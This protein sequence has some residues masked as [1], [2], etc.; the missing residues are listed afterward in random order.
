MSEERCLII[1]RSNRLECLLEILVE[2][3]RHTPLPPLEPETVVV[4]NRGMATWLSRNLALR[5]N[6]WANPDFPHPR[7]FIDSLLGSALGSEARRLD[8]FSREGLSLALLEILPTLL[9]QEEFAPIARYLTSRGPGLH[10]EGEIDLKRLQLAEKI[11][12]LF[13]QYLVYRTDMVLEWERGDSGPLSPAGVERE[14]RWQPVL[15]RKLAARYGSPAQLFEQA[16]I[17]L[18]AGRLEASS[19]L[20]TRVFLFGVTTLPPVYLAMVNAAARILPIHLLLFSPSREYWADLLPPGEIPRRLL[21]RKERGS[22]GNQIQVASPEQLHLESG[23]PLLA[24]WGKIGREFQELIEQQT[25]YVQPEGE[26]ECFVAPAVEG[27]LH[28]KGQQQ[29][30]SLLARLQSDILELHPPGGAGG[31]LRE[32]P[33]NS[34]VIHCCHSPLREVEVLQ[35]QLL[36]MF[37]AEGL[38]PGEAVVMVPDIETYAP[39]IEAVF[40]RP[41]HDRRFIPFRIADRRLSREAP[42]LDALLELFELSQSRLTLSGVL[43]F[44]SREPVMSALELDS[45]RLRRIEQWLNQ[46]AVRWGIDEEDRRRYEQPADRQNTWLFGLDRLILGY[47]LPGEGS[48]LFADILPLDD[49]EGQDAQLAGVLLRTAKAVFYLAKE[50]HSARS[51]EGWS[52]LVRWSLTTFFAPEERCGP[53]EEW[54]RQSLRDALASLINDAGQAEFTRPVE[55]PAFL[56]LL[57]HRLDEGGVSSGFLEGGLT[58][59]TMLPM[60]TIPFPVVALLGMND[61]EFPRQETPPAFDLMA[62]HPRPGD[63]CR[64]NDDRYLFLESLLS[65]RQRLYISYVGRGI[66][67]NRPLP[68]SPLVD[69]LLDS[70]VMMSGDQPQSLQ[71]MLS[72]RRRFVLEHPL[73]PFSRRYLRGE[74]PL[75]F[76]YAREYAPAEEKTGGEHTCCERDERGGHLFPV[77]DNGYGLPPF[78]ETTLG[79]LHRFFK[80]P[81]RWYA[82]NRLG[83]RLPGSTDLSPDREPLFPDRLA[84][85]QRANLVLREFLGSTGREVGELKAM[86]PELR[87]LLAAAGEL[88]LGGGA[89]A[90]LSEL[91][92]SIGPLSA[93]L[94]SNPGGSPLPDMALRIEA[95]EHILG[96]ELRDRARAGLLRWSAGR[97]KPLFFLSAW[98]DHLAL[99]AR[100]P[101]DQDHQCIMA[102]RGEEKKRPTV[103]IHIFYLLES[104]V[105][106]D[107][108]ADLLELKERGSREPLP[109]FP[110][111]SHAYCWRLLNPGRSGDEEE[112]EKRARREALEAY[113]GNEF[114]GWGSDGSDPYNSLI[115]QEPDPG[116]IRQSEG[117][118]APGG[119]EWE[120]FIEVADR[121]FGPMLRALERVESDKISGGTPGG[122]PGGKL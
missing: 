92:A 23:H 107:T 86:A 66:K 11:A 29:P 75:L 102:C 113:H 65:A 115:F 51:I 32:G 74:H 50:A 40:R 108:L 117:H 96:G 114:Q 1:S 94:A 25:Q 17:R 47:A 20:P 48:N 79:D 15:W 88:P 49:I 12:Y 111:A 98:L 42:L 55:L 53:G 26:E 120:N 14:N 100:A 13:D 105:A 36:A 67:D 118:P 93:F 27:G 119:V 83:V 10:S 24:S 58:F 38:N 16:L 121:V 90:A 52:E 72:A 9:E 104:V 6:V 57:R 56:R 44:I 19:S 45:G 109:F 35:D 122:K 81:A 101:E 28:L 77:A 69:E 85:Y 2:Q 4:Q 97:D 21:R 89:D 3:L 8:T 91:L 37:D 34:I 84:N 80:N 59:C 43:G 61:R 39:L 46:G 78:S 82:Q 60:R 7:R 18:R 30:G 64:R 99:C 41:T 63:R 33:D 70:L 71:E 73:Q 68:P 62:A 54:Q 106:V 22:E 31:A 87:R 5:F 110:A 95:G 112:V 103:D 76:T 116:E